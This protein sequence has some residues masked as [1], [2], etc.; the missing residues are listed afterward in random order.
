M[1]HEKINEILKKQKAVGLA[2]GKMGIAIYLYHQSGKNSQ[3][4]LDET[5]AEELVQEIYSNINDKYPLN[6]FNGLCGIGIGLDYLVRKSYVDGEVDDI[7]EEIDN[8]VFQRT[9]YEI[10]DITELYDILFYLIIRF[11]NG[12]K[13]RDNRLIFENLAIRLIDTIYLNRNEDFYEESI[14]FSYNYRLALYLYILG[15]FHQLNVYTYRIERLL[16]EM[17]GR[18]FS[19]IPVLQANRLTL[20]YPVRIVAKTLSQKKWHDYADFLENHLSLDH[21]MNKEMKNKNIFFSDGIALIYVLLSLYNRDN[22]QKIKMD[23]KTVYQKITNSLIWRK[24]RTDP[25]FLSQRIGLDGYLGLTMIL[26]SI[27]SQ[28]DTH[29]N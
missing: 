9:G 22:N 8:L 4:K 14:P 2:Y 12:L 19:R 18:V 26:D 6:L 10:R 27:K 3:N 28:M 7:L 17:S 1:K 11:E 21:I 15:R 20:L 16:E 23:P 24:F 25:A 13:H 5:L 29:E